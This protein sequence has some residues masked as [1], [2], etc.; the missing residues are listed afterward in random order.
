MTTRTSLYSSAALSAALNARTVR[1]LP[2]LSDT[3]E[4]ASAY[5]SADIHVA[6][7]PLSIYTGS[8]SFMP[9]QASC[10]DNRAHASPHSLQ[11]L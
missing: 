4:L 9:L 3:M 11:M 1:T 2:R 10:K 5:A 6:Y 7:C 8:C